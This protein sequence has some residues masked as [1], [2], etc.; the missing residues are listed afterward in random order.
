[1]TKWL[2][3]RSHSN[4]LPFLALLHSLLQTQLWKWNYVFASIYLAAHLR[5]KNLLTHG[6]LLG[7]LFD[8]N[9]IG[10]MYRIFIA[11]I[12][13]L[14]PLFFNFFWLEFP[15][16]IHMFQIFFLFQI[17]VEMVFFFTTYS[18]ATLFFI[19]F[20]SSIFCKALYFS[21]IETFT[22]CIFHTGSSTLHCL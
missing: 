21:V 5:L 12:P 13:S 7:F 9:S 3:N 6:F 22:L 8:D 15:D 2:A 17:H 10:R 19:L 18:S 16:Q 14:L 1:M 4:L 20:P 11:S